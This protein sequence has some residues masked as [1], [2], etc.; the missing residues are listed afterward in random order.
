MKRFKNFEGVQLPLIRNQVDNVYAELKG[1][2]QT[3][4]GLLVDT[5][6]EV[7]KEFG[8]DPGGMRDLS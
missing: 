8:N 4:F 5:M 1:E 3:A 2:P 7:V 6:I